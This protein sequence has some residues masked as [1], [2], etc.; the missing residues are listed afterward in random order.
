MKVMK[1]YSQVHGTTHN[2]RHPEHLQLGAELQHLLRH[3]AV[4]VA[5]DLGHA[6]HGAGTPHVGPHPADLNI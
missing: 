6:L 5:V 2:E 4:K 1:D 3:H